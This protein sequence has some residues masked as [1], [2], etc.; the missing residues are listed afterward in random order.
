MSFDQL[1]VELSARYKY[2]NVYLVID[3]LQ[4]FI[5]GEGYTCSLL[6]PSDYHVDIDENRISVLINTKDEISGFMIG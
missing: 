6:R 1:M 2:R 5:K 3:D 4:Q